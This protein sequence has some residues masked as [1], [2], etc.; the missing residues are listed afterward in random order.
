[1]C[2]TDSISTRLQTF[3]EAD[4]DIRCAYLFGSALSD[5]F[6]ASSDIDLAVTTGQPLTA[7]HRQALKSA[8]ETELNRDVDLIDLAT[9]TGTILKQAMRGECLICRTPA[10][11]AQLIKRL[12]YDQEDMQ[13]LRDRMMRLRRERFAYGH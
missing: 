13:P 10:V 5:R 6:S 8:I 7:E 9:A 4:T 3:L 2:Q 12:I 1:M 11:K